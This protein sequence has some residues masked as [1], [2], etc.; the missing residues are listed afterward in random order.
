MMEILLL[1]YAKYSNYIVLLLNS[2]EGIILP[3]MKVFLLLAGQSNRFWPLKEK[4]LFTLCGETVFEH[5]VAALR[6]VG[7][8]DIHCIVSEMNIEE[9]QSLH[10]E[11]QYTKQQSELTG[12]WGALM[13][14]LPQFDDQP[15]MVIGGNDLVDASLMQEVASKI[16]QYDGAIAAKEVHSYFPGGYIEFSGDRLLHVV[17]KPGEGNEPSNLVNIIIHAHKSSHEFLH[18]L[19]QVQDTSIDGHEVAL[20]ALFKRKHYTPVPYSGSWT[21]IKYPWHALNVVEHQ[22]DLLQGVTIDP[23]ANI[24]PSAVITGNVYIGKR[25]KVLPNSTITGPTYIDDDAVVG[26]GALVRSSSIGK[27]SVVGFGTEIAR[28]CLGD[29]VWTHSNYIGDSIIGNNVS[30]GAGTVTGNLRLDESEIYSVVK[31]V[32]TATNRTKLGTV[33]GS[34]CRIG[35][36]TSFAPGVKIGSNTFISSAVY[37]NRDIPEGSF[38]QMKHGEVQIKENHTPVPG[39]LQR[40]SV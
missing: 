29:D 3:L 38:V 20:A 28:S 30:F 4:P 32:K 22:L 40:K 5:Q 31:G 35:I 6:S 27:R 34:N 39:V 19:K 17:E 36:Q 14:T 7:F 37:V 2:N 25:V 23:T 21:P 33:I 1:Y 12:I 10:P 16:P 15:I 24:H 26:N 13:S 18:E 8:T 9:L 11:L